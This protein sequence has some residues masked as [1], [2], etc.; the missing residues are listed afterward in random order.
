MDSEFFLDHFKNKDSQKLVRYATVDP[1][2]T[3]GLPKLL[4]DGEGA[5]TEKGYPHLDSYNPAANDRVMLI[6]KVI[7]GKVIRSI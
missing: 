7:I 6:S 3:S 5:V 1:N 4:F 2:H